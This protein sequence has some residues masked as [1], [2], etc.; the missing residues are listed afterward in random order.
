MTCASAAR[1]QVDKMGYCVSCVYSC[2]ANEDVKAL[3][4]LLEEALAAKVKLEKGC[5]Q[6]QVERAQRLAAA[7]DNTRP[8]TKTGAE[9]QEPVESTGPV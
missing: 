8:A 4:P 5:R 3:K 7:R 9:S 2:R 6:L 1:L